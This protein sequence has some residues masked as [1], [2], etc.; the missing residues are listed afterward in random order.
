MA[1]DNFKPKSFEQLMTH[2]KL[3]SLPV[4]QAAQAIIVL[5]GAGHIHPAK[6][7]TKETRARCDGLNDI[8]AKMHE[9]LRT[10]HI[11]HRL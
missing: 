4:N 7:S 8:S 6:V 2:G 5:T 9:A 1:E 10:S 11:W 3:K